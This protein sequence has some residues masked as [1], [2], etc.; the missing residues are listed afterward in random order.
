MSEVGAVNRV[1]AVWATTALAKDGRGERGDIP[2]VSLSAPVS[3]GGRVY[4]CAGA[5]RGKH[6]KSRHSR[7]NPATFAAIERTQR[8]VNAP[9]RSFRR[10]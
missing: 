5:E 4:R 1:T 2:G 10:I 6:S 8:H 7:G 9:L 3:E